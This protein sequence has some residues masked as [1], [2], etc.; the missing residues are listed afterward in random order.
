M[1]GNSDDSPI[2]KNLDNNDMNTSNE[3]YSTDIAPGNSLFEIKV[4]RFRNPNKIII[5]NLNINSLPNKFDQLNDTVLNYIDVLVLT[6]TKIDDSFPTAQFLVRGFSKPYRLDRNSNGGVFGTY[7]PPSQNDLYFF[8][9]LDKALDIYSCYEK[10]LLI[11]DFN[12]EVNEPL[13]DSFLY[14]HDLDNLVKEKTGFK[15]IDNPS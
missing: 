6:E 10:V 12:A 9:N 2:I 1:C 14:E 11:G 13:V 3:K 4:L 15:N 8:D 5:G 7:H